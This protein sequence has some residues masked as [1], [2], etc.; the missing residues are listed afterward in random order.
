M[1]EIRF[2]GRV[3]IVTGAGS[4]IGRSVPELLVREGGSVVAADLT[5]D[6]LDWCRGV[7]RIVAAAADVAGADANDALVSLAVESFEYLSQYPNYLLFNGLLF[8][9]GSAFEKLISRFE[10][11]RF[12]RGWILVTLVKPA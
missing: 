4:G 8:A 3:A 11:L 6:R 9:I 12:L 5:D 1:S 7:E 2:D 10:V